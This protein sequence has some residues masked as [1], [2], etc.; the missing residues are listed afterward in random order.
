MPEAHVRGVRL[1]YEAQGASEPLLLLHGGLGTARL[2]WWREIPVFAAH[3]RVIAPDLRGYGRSSPPRDFPLDFYERDADDMAALLD[4][5]DA[6]PAHVL[7]WSDGAVVALLLAVRHPAS[8]RTLVVV[9]GEAHILPQE[10]DAW[11]AL[12]DTS[13]W[14]EGALRRFIAEQGP[15]NWPGILTRMLEGYN[16]VLAMR[17]GEIVRQRLGEIRC[18]T[19]I[20]HGSADPTVPVSHA[21]E[22]RDAIHG[23]ELHVYPDTGHFPQREHADDFRTR[24]LRFLIRRGGPPSA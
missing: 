11:P 14:S 2:H 10:R 3:F 23:A 22:L 5:A 18:P 24:V 13:A 4:A 8:V 19:L 7:G 6:A 21:Y 15:A 20:L 17:G 12:V 16:R 1:H 9:S